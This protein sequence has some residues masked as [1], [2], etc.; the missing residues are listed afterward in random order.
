MILKL[1][2]AA[3]A[4]FIFTPLFGN[5]FSEFKLNGYR[6][7]A[8]EDRHAC[9]QNITESSMSNC[10][11][12][13]LGNCLCTSFQIC[14][15]SCQLC[16]EDKERLGMLGDQEG[17]S[18]FNFT[19]SDEQTGE[20]QCHSGCARGVDCCLTSQPCLNGG[21]CVPQYSTV[22]KNRF[23]CKCTH[24]R[25]G[26]RCEDCADGYTGH[27]CQTKARSCSGYKN[28]SRVGK[29]FKVFDKN[30]NLFSVF[31]DFDEERSWTLIQSF[32]FQERKRFKPSFV[33]DRIRNQDAPNFQAY[34]MSKA[35]MQS[36]AKNCTKW[37]ITCDFRQGEKISYIDY[38][39][40]SLTNLD[41]LTFNG[42]RC[43]EVDYIDI[44][45]TN[46]TNCTAFVLQSH[47]KNVNPYY[48]GLHFDSF[49]GPSFSCEHNARNGSKKCGKSGEDD[50]GFFDCRSTKHRCSAHNA[51]LT[52]AWLGG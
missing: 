46:C 18:Y 19:A 32:A 49:L 11:Q 12:H 9:F 30:D 47:N 37:R 48:M 1:A 4:C 6:N 14:D 15:G 31:C 43:V 24:Y 25:G 42:N 45:G 40:T 22:D 23:T 28:S 20:Q 26:E 7:K 13:C 52:S 39:E 5:S 33:L 51:S 38:V 29:I 27:L 50:F 21:T 41:I 17:C 16:S 10:F 2:V 36:V 35:R 34:R 3:Y 8:L 44:R